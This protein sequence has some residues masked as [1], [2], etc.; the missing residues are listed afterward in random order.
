MRTIISINILLL[1][2]IFFGCA[3]KSNPVEPI[4]PAEGIFGKWDWVKTVPREGDIPIITPGTTGFTK[5]Y[6]FAQDST[7]AAWVNDSIIYQGKYSI[8]RELNFFTSPDSGDVLSINEAWFSDGNQWVINWQ[9]RD[10]LQLIGLCLD[11]ADQVF[12][13]IP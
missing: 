11:C 5:R 6:Q 12:S 8:K 13:R 7:F 10:T 2:S 1:L 9:H 3:N 4:A